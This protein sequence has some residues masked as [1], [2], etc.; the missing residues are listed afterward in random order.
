LKRHRSLISRLALLVAA[1]STATFLVTGVVINHLVN[2]HFN[3][4]DVARLTTIL[5]LTNE[6]LAQ[7]HATA[8]LGPIR[9]RLQQVLKENEGHALA[10]FDGNG[11]ALF[12]TCD[13]DFPMVRRNARSAALSG[14]AMQSFVWQEGGR[15]HRVIAATVPTANPDAPFLFVAAALDMEQHTTFMS[16]FHKFLWASVILGSLVTGFLAWLTA[17]RGLAPLRGIA[18][19]TRKIAADRLGDRLPLDTVPAE[20]LDL[21]RSFNTMLT[22]L[23]E[24]FRR[25]SNYSTD[26]AHELRTPVGNLT[27]QTEVMLS[28]ER[29]AHEYREVLYA[30]LREYERLSKMISDL[31]LLAK[32]DNRLV[33][34]KRGLVDLARDMDELIEFYRP[35]TEQKGVHLARRGGG[36]VFGDSP[37]LRRAASNLLS[38]AARHTPQGGRITL[39]IEPLDSGEVRISVENTG[40]TIAPEHLPRLFDRF[41]RVDAS[42]QH[43]GEGVG[44][45]LAIVK[46]IAQ[47]HGGSV[48]VSSSDGVTVFAMTLPSRP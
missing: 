45:G 14:K 24:S 20:L 15:P 34:P 1:I 35:L 48:S 7:M 10:V 44:L 8:E 40:K 19:A 41:Y 18:D 3:Q 21:A 26:I 29:S 6:A 36:Q 27:T 30:N 47:A 46:S 28:K 37:A 25:L 33:V 13:I 22:G 38:N 4:L 31:L 39:S 32:V 16:A 2:A 9:E 17:R 11:R 23:D 5:K 43:N 12:A 42:R